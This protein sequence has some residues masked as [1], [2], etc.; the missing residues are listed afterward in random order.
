MNLNALAAVHDQLSATEIGTKN[1]LETLPQPLSLDP[2]H[3]NF[4]MFVRRSYFSFLGD[5]SFIY[6]QSRSKLFQLT[7]KNNHFTLANHFYL[8]PESTYLS[9]YILYEKS[10]A[11][12]TV[13]RI[14]LEYLGP[15]S[16][17]TVTNNKSDTL[18]VS[19]RLSHSQWHHIA[20]CF[21]DNQ[22]IAYIN[23]QK[24]LEGR[25]RLLTRGQPNGAALYVGGN[26]GYP[27]RFQGFISDVLGFSGI[28]TSNYINDLINGIQLG[29]DFEAVTL[30]SNLDHVTYYGSLNLNHI[31]PWTTASPVASFNTSVSLVKLGK[32]SLY[33]FYASCTVGMKMG[34]LLSLGFDT[35]YFGFGSS[36]L[37][38]LCNRG[39]QY[40]LS[41]PLPDEDCVAAISAP[42]QT[43]RG[44]GVSRGSAALKFL[45]SASTLFAAPHALETLNNEIRA[46]QILPTSATLEVTFA[47]SNFVRC[48]VVPKENP[49]P[50]REEVMNRNSSSRLAMVTGGIPFQVELNGLHENTEYT[51]YCA[52]SLFSPIM[53]EFNT[54]A[55]KSAIIPTVATRIT[56][57]TVLLSATFTTSDS[58]TKCVVLTEGSQKPTA[59]AS[60]EDSVG[61]CADET[62]S[63]EGENFAVFCSGLSPAAAYDGY[64]IQSNGFVSGPATFY[65]SF[66]T[67]THVAFDKNTIILQSSFP[68]EGVFICSLGSADWKPSLSD[69][70]STIT[71]GKPYL[72]VI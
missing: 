29:S 23:G 40:L 5:G 37:D 61:I 47:T 22:T 31:F 19:L 20:V 12:M 62:L 9:R 6:C 36:S 56:T 70:P 65:T 72:K 24:L 49:P 38:V 64:C 60:L 2:Y 71:E 16:L 48:L 4:E 21:G 15:T 39:L 51:A 44:F 10:N 14:T 27:G 42:I 33:R 26:I 25:L 46:I 35:R 58:A 32:H 57:T 50:T 41:K 30:S 1:L 54:T 45:V 11:S 67:E 3:S 34:P 17:F 68:T 8:A 66:A 69:F 43:I 53:L 7:E 13:F 63:V 55:L 59:D 52:Q 28:L 18:T